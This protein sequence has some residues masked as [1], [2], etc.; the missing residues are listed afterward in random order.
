MTICNESKEDKINIKFLYVGN[1]FKST[2]SETGIASSDYT[3]VCI[4]SVSDEN[5]TEIFTPREIENTHIMIVNADEKDDKAI[6]SLLKFTQ[7][8]KLLNNEGALIGVTSDTSPNSMFIKTLCHNLDHVILVNNESIYSP[9]K[10][11]NAIFQGGFMPIEFCEVYDVF[12]RH[13]VSVFS[14]FD[15]ASG[16]NITDQLDFYISE[17]KSSCNTDDYLGNCF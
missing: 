16:E 17:I 8:F 3:V 15:F 2:A 12:K 10:M 4:K 5:S 6:E 14:S 9:L 1:S 11:L 7:H 13:K